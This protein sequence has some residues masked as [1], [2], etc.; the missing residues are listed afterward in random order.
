MTSAPSI[1]ALPEVSILMAVFNRLDLTRR[2]LETLEKS[3]AGIRYEVLI[4]DDVSTD[5]TREFLKTLGAPYRVFLNERKGNFAI[6]NNLAAREARSERL[7]FLNNDTELAPG[8]Y[9]PMREGLA[10]FPDAGFIG[11]FQT[12]PDTRRYDHMGVVYSPWIGPAHYGQAFA[13]VPGWLRTAEFTPWS[14][15]TAACC[16]THRDT[17]WAAGGFDEDYIN[18]CED[19]DLCLKMHRL[20]R[21]HYTANRSMIVHH[22]GASPGR[23]KFNDVNMVRLKSIWAGYIRE[24]FVQKDARLFAKTCLRKTL[25]YPLKAHLGKVL[26]CVLILAG[27]R[28]V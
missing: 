23:K 2:C 26:V 20:G 27:L 4:V 25:V 3:L 12:D 11:N 9:E 24:H 22:K 5:G 8:W 6:N 18:G 13:R 10:R 19:I 15:V 21:R 17:F 16:L 28:H 7:L 14:A 1:T